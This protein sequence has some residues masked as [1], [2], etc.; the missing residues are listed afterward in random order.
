MHD[1]SG[2]ALSQGIRNKLGNQNSSFLTLMQLNAFRQTC[3]FSLNHCILFIWNL[4]AFI[5]SLVFMLALWPLLSRFFS[6]SHSIFI[7][8][9]M[10]SNKTMLMMKSIHRHYI[11]H[12]PSSV[13]KQKSDW[14]G[15][16]G[17]KS[18]WGRMK[19]KEE[20]W[21]EESES[22]RLTG[23]QAIINFRCNFNDKIY[24]LGCH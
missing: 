21:K 4:S 24:T 12:K 8:F 5:C 19:K 22:E 18:E 7:R 17:S 1:S 20:R 10:A 11:Q 23:S 9:I 3:F 14:M 2:S 6:L 16:V 15:W 13:M